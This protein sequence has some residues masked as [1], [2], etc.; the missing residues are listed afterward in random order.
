[1]TMRVLTGDRVT[2]HPLDRATAHA[3]AENRLHGT[4]GL[5][6]RHH[7]RAEQVFLFTVTCGRF[8]SLGTGR[9]PAC[10]V[11]QAVRGRPRNRRANR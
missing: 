1:M 5:L 10:L 6:A 8:G 3:I 2:L 9:R 7:W 11:A 4:A